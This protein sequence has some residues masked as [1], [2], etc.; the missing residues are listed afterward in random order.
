MTRKPISAS[1]RIGATIRSLSLSLHRDEHRAWRSATWPDA[2]LALA[3]GHGEVAVDAHDL[4]GRAHLGTEDGIDAGEA[5]EREHGLLH[6]DMVELRRAAGRRSPSGLPAMT[7]AA[8]AA[9]G[10]PITLA[11][12]GTV[13]EARG[14]TSRM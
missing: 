8:I 6:G 10:L 11:T 12:N 1:S 14:L 4:A 3:E 2:E 9:I 5:R 13:R 7:S